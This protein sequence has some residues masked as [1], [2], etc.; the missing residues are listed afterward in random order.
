LT[1]YSVPYA[2]FS[3]SPDAPSDLSP[4]VYFTDQSTGN[5]IN[6]WQWDFGSSNSNQQNPQF[7]FPGPGT[8]TVSLLVSTPNGCIDSVSQIIEVKSDFSFYVPNAFTPNDDG[9]NDYFYPSGLGIS[10]DGYEF[11]IFNR[12][13][14]MIWNT[15]EFGETWDG[16]AIGGSDLVQQD[17][18][19]W[20]VALKQMDGTNKNY[21]GHV[22]LI[23]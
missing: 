20:K 6:S 12:W 4:V 5:G 3:Y 18:Y 13:G 21:I 1:L 15:N 7:E 8:Y 10:N 22:K 9:I 14:Q 11:S 16:K 2:E 17:I 23:R 19:I